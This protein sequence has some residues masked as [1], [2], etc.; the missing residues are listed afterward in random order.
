MYSLPSGGT[1]YAPAGQIGT[2]LNSDG[3]NLLPISPCQVSFLE[4][5]DAYPRSSVP[6]PIPSIF[7]SVVMIQNLL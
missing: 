7:G 4:R 1:L 6:A 2:I 5:L 3:A